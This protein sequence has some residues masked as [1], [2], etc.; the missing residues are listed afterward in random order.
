MQIEKP[1][2]PTIEDGNY[3]IASKCPKCDEPVQLAIELVTRLTADRHRSVVKV[4][5][6]GKASAHRCADPDQLTFDL[7]GEP[8]EDAEIVDDGKALPWLRPVQ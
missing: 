5:L 1:P 6:L 2:I 4:S 3:L 7:D 8:V